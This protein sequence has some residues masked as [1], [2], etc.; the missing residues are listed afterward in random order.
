MA[1]LNE[2]LHAAANWAYPGH[3]ALVAL[4]QGDG[5]LAA[6]GYGVGPRGAK[7]GDLHVEHV[8]RTHGAPPAPGA[9][10][11]DEGGW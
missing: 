9:S 3:H 6:W 7:E 10:R 11:V 4:Q 1:K 8:N 2:D 5:R